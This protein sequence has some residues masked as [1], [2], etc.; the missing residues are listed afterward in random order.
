M[1]PNERYGKYTELKGTYDDG[2]ISL[3]FIMA[4]SVR[5]LGIVQRRCLSSLS[6]G[7]KGLS[8]SPGGMGLT[9]PSFFARD[10]IRITAS[11]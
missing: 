11:L 2:M 9:G 8:K 7:D 5:S 6:G 10:M 3:Y 4:G 1:N